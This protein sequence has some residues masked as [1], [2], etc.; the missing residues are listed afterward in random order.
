MGSFRSSGRRVS[1]A[2]VLTGFLVLL[3]AQL[4]GAVTAGAADTV[5]CYAV[6]DDGNGSG[7]SQDSG[8]EDLLTKINPDDADPATNETSIGAGTDTFN[9]EASAF[10]P[11]TE[12]LFAVDADQLGT[13]DLT[14]GVFTAKPSPLGSGTGA[15]G[16]VQYT[17]V[18]SITFDPA[19]GT[20]YGG[21]RVLGDDPDVL[22]VID[23]DTGAG[24]PDAFGPGVDY[25]RVTPLANESRLDDLAMDFDGT[26]YAIS[27]VGGHED[28]LVTIDPDTGALTDVGATG[29]ND[30]EGLAIAPDGRLFGTTG[31]ESSEGGALWDID[32][33][34]AA[35][36]N[37]RALDNAADY[38]SVACLVEAGTTPSPSPSPSVIPTETVTTGPT[39]SPSVGGV[40]VI[41]ETGPNAVP[42]LLVLGIATIA[43]GLTML[44]IAGSERED[45][46]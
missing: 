44:W 34:T 27:N 29:V 38:E 46:A 36:T 16:T 9:I 26:L 32:K 1:V 23:P 4:L 11:G 18:D 10:Q 20:L 6:A 24:V 25:L 28:H 12:I 42:G 14:T 19:T 31:Q 30:M 33:A 13:I 39:A 7:G 35:A 40:K 5:V 43:A 15:A 21:Q 22:F 3:V 41:P 37:G 17:D 8:A 45:T 2:V